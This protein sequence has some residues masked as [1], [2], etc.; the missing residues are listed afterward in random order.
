MATTEPPSKLKH[1]ACDECRQRKL[2]CSKDPD[3]C[4]RCK[5][6][7]INCHY[8]EQKTM[9]RPRKRQFIETTIKATQQDTQA[10]PQPFYV[11]GIDVFNASSTFTNYTT[12]LPNDSLAYPAKTADGPAPWYFGDGQMLNGPPINFDAMGFRFGDDNVPPLDQDLQLSSASNTDSEGSPP[13]STSPPPCSCLA[14]MYLALAA[15]QQFPNDVV[16]ALKTIRG[17]AATASQCLWCPQCG[18]VL[19]DNTTPPIESFQN[20]M[21]L[22]TILPIVANGYGRLLKMI[23]EETE[24]AQ[25]AGETKTF[26]FHEYGGLCVKSETTD[27]MLDCAQEEMMLSKMEMSPAQWRTTVRALLRVDIYGHEQSGFKHKGL[28]DLVSEME[29][30]QRT[31]HEILDARAAAGTLDTTQLGHGFFQTNDGKCLGEQ[32]RGCLDILQMAKIAIDNLVIA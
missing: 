21:L 30:R 29:Y 13:Q 6:E 14:S 3:G 18:A 19:L 8:S 17:A 7:N 27:E 20:T 32:T 25:A 5:R 12:I 10:A 15:L 4:N 1:R 11:D 2:A 16:A 26:K 28:K 24:A 9:G 31:R 22:G 23:D